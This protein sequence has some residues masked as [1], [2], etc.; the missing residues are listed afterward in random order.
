MR[1]DLKVATDRGAPRKETS[2]QFASAE[3]ND[4]PSIM[5][6]TSTGPFGGKG[7]LGEGFV[8]IAEGASC[9]G[10]LEGHVLASS[11]TR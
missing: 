11:P 8:L 10:V 2:D 7:K 9:S 6:R 3:A 5:V 4:V 1:M